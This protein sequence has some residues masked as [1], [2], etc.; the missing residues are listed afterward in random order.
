MRTPLAVS[1]EGVARFLLHAQHLHGAAASGRVGRVSPVATLRKI[2]RLEC[3]QI[4]PV[5]VVE[6][7]QH[8]VLAARLPGYDPG[9][10]ETLRR[11]GRVFEYWANAACIIPIEAFPVFEGT[12][13]RFRRRLGPELGALRPIVRRMMAALESQG[14]LPAR[15]F[16]SPERLRGA[17][18][19]SEARTKATS[20]ALTLL[21]R[22]GA[23]V[24]AKRD[25]AERYFDLS[26]RVIP[27]GLLR[28]A[29]ALTTADADDA[30]LEMYLQAYRVFDAGDPRFGWRAMT[31]RGRRAAVHRRV[32]DGSIVP[33]TIGG[34]ARQY[35][36]LARDV[37]ALRRHERAAA[38]GDDDACPAARFLPPLDNLLWRRERIADL[39]GFRYLWE[40]YLPVVRRR[41]G[42]YAMPI[43]IGSRLVGRIDPRLDRARGRLVV[44]LLH[45]ESHVA[46]TRR[47]RERLTAGLEAFARFHGAGDFEVER[48]E[49]SRLR[50]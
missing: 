46:I 39:F 11:R 35:F 32:R 28:D 30:M 40:G 9:S 45:L 23:L 34:V 44:Q 6:R 49:P 19:L 5:A 47:L 29:A 15:G 12:R 2:Q 8:L 38:E 10:L 48:T 1:R 4:D 36:V 50:V 27:P 18:D 17:W 13:R 37:P 33:L 43:L 31:T 22:T 41:Y 16:A 21:F 7:N 25:G 14:P 42:H 20:H 26:E 3:V 24:V